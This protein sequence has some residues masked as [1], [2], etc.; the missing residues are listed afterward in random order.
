MKYGPNWLFS[1]RAVLK[2]FDDHLVCG[3]WKV[4]YRDIQ[5]AVLYSIR[6]FFLPGY[7]RRVD[8]VGKTYHFGLQGGRYWRGT[9]PFTVQREKGRIGYSPFSIVVRAVLIGCLLHLL[10]SWLNG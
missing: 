3:D 6:S 10:W 1:R 2:V 9:L 4:D 7:V 8:T 5:S